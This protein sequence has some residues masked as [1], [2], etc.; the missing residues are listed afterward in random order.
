MF[1]EIR[2]ALLEAW[3]NGKDVV[4]Q[5]ALGD[6]LDCLVGDRAA[7]R[8][9]ARGEAVRELSKRLGR[10][11]ELPVDLLR[12]EDGPHREITGRQTLRNDQNVGFDFIGL[13]TPKVAGSA[14]PA[15]DLVGDEGNVVLP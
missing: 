4:E 2:E 6:E 5:P 12:N 9:P 13:R 8:V 10:G 1:A 14:K 15:Y 3:R 7:K 11:H